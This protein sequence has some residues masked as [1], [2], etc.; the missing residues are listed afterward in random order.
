MANIGLSQPYYAKYAVNNGAVTYTG[1]KKL[2]KAIDV[3][4]TVDNKDPVVLYANN[5]PAESVSV[6]GGGTA[7]LGIDE[8]ALD[9]AA[10]VL[11]MAAPTEQ[12]PGVTFLADA[13]APYVGLGFIVMKVFENVIKWRMIVIY[14]AQFKLP[15]YQINTKGQTVEFQTP[16]LEAQILRDD[17]TPSK[18]QYWND[19]ATEAD[20]IAALTAKLGT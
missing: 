12:A 15:D 14:K 19:Y 18:W 3:D 11:G 10:D 20:A 13:N 16:S 7:T 5:G 2:G 17:A 1:L 9:V 8:L 6:F 4:I